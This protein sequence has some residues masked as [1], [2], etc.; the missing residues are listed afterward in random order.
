MRMKLIAGALA[1]AAAVA[2]PHWT[3]AV[4]ASEMAGPQVEHASKINIA[5][6]KHVLKLTAA[7]QRYWAPVEAALIRI[8]HRQARHDADGVIT[9]VRRRAV[10]V[11]FDSAAI[12]QLAAAARPLVRVLD[13]EQKQ[14]ALMLAQEMGFGWVLARLN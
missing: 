7:Q 14:S 8:S 2:V 4:R 3:G 9:R 11:V 5:R 10:A 13:D 12:A 6:I 1:L